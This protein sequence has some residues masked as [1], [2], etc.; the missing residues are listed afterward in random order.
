[1]ETDWKVGPLSHILGIVPMTTVA[2]A[3][4]DSFCYFCMRR[5][6]INYQN[7]PT[8]ARVRPVPPVV[9]CS[10]TFHLVRTH[11]GGVGGFKPPIHFHC[12]LHAKK[13]GEVQKECKIAYVLNGSPLSKIINTKWIYPLVIRPFKE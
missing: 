5:L 11:L 9:I 4:N 12:V 10:G 3:T 8:N 7:Q 6:F 13:G 1:M 2:M